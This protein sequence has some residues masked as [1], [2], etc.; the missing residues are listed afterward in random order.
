[1]KYIK[2]PIPIEAIQWLGTNFD[3]ITN[4]MGD[5]HPIINNKNE[6]VIS[7]L[8]GE[9]CA[10]VGSYVI[11]GVSGHDYYP[12]DKSLFEQS[13]TPIRETKW[14][15]IKCNKCERFFSTDTPHLFYDNIKEE[16]KY[17]TICPHCKHKVEWEIN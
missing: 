7:T 16:Y 10:P 11:C 17:W 9:M 3:Q 4:F 12:C 5:N 8:E 1:M 6:L 14:H 2:K 15:H 13:Y